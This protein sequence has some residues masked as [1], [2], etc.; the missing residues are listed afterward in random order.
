MW[1]FPRWGL[2]WM[3]PSPA[4]FYSLSFY[5]PLSPTLLGKKD[6]LYL[7]FHLGRGSLVNSADN[8]G[9]PE[10]TELNAGLGKEALLYTLTTVGKS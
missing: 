9:N 3:A 8:I 1:R 7:L 4:L 6:Q 10:Y 2:Y 5:S